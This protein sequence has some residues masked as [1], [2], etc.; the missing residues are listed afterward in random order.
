MRLEFI[1][2]LDIGFILENIKKRLYYSYVE[3]I[4]AVKKEMSKNLINIGKIIWN[5][6]KGKYY[7]KICKL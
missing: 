6:K 7:E 3:E 1:W 2:N 4:K 5:L